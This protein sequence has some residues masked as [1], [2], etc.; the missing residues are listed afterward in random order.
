[1]QRIVTATTP[2]TPSAG[3]RAA[4]AL[5]LLAA[6]LPLATPARATVRVVNIVDVGGGFEYSPSTVFATLGDTIRWVNQSAS[7]HN[8]TSGISPTPDGKFASPTLAPAATYQRAFT[9]MGPFRYFD[10]LNPAT[11]GIIRVTRAVVTIKDFS[12]NPATLNVT[13]GDT[14]VWFNSGT[15]THTST[16]GSGGI[17][18]GTWDTGFLGHNASAAIPMMV[19]GAQQ[20]FCAVHSFSMVG[21]VTVGAAV[22]VEGG[23]AIATRLLF[24]RPNPARGRVQLAYELAAR[25]TVR[26]ALLDASGQLVRVLVDGPQDAGRHTV[27]WDGRGASG[28]RAASGTYFYRLEAQGTRITRRFTWLRG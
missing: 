16:S 1:M 8:V 6:A 28:V 22:G 12:F 21:T 26:M 24:A 20:Y 10:S 27:S 7:S 19:G 15:F 11:R 17:E 2:A 9:L 14:V 3:R 4:L 18:N 13:L 5:L 23:G 25:G